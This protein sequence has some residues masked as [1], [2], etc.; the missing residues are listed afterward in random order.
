MVWYRYL[1]VIAAAI[2]TTACAQTDNLRSEPADPESVGISSDRLLR[3]TESNQ[4]YVENGTIPGLVTM[5]SRRGEIVYEEVVGQ[6]G[7]ND[8]NAMRKDDLF[9][10]YSMTKPVT[11]V[12]AMQLYDQGHFQLNDP[13]SKFLPEFSEMQVL[14]DGETKPASR[15][16]TMLHLLTHT[17]GLTHGID[18]NH[19][20][21]AAF[22][23]ARLYQSES[24]EQMV[25]GLAELPLIY[26][27][28]TQWH[29]SA[30]MDVLALIVERISGLSFDVYLE[31]NIFAPLGMTDTSFS[32]SDAD[33]HRFLPS[34]Y[35][36]DGVLKPVEERFGEGW[37]GDEI[38]RSPLSAVSYD[39]CGA[40]CDYYTVSLFAGSGGLVSTAEDYMKFAM[41]LEN[42]GELNGVEI[43][44][45]KTLDM[46]TSDHLPSV[47]NPMGS[48]EPVATGLP[49]FLGFGLGFGVT[50]DSIGSGVMGSTGSFF[51][52][53]AAGTTF[54]VDPVEELAVVSMMQR[55]DVWPVHQASLQVAIYQSLIE[56]NGCRIVR[57]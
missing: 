20:V 8:P 30:S 57:D 22:L 6:R 55:Q 38:I 35:V 18:P 45:P 25:Q 36:E 48:P 41:M 47:L 11:A 52:T 54:W 12:A 24:L 37:L 31:Q 28:G 50:I 51:W 2:S 49:P 4:A 56:C 7:L 32:V 19:P 39:G 34:H 16:I 40:L 17:A 23:E 13:I 27:P 3:I 44:S 53:G 5:V 29:Y 33:R 9:R 10:I 1:S 26:E 43:L 14:T 46:M 42:G 21:D 15:P